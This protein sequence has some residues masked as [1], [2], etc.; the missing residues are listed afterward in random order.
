[1]HSI[2]IGTAVSSAPGLA[3]GF[4]K[5]GELPD[6]RP[7]Q[8]PVMIMRG[9]QTGPV[10]WLHACVHGNEYLRHLHFA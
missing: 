1:M 3:K 7:V 5:T 4:L 2:E 6:G 9:A 8:T 10:L